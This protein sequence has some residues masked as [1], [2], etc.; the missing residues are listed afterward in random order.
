MTNFQIKYTSCVS[1]KIVRETDLEI[2][3]AKK[4][5]TQAQGDAIEVRAIKSKACF[6]FIKSLFN[7][8]NNE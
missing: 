7:L 3:F 4:K 5:K 1:A 2:K 8:C 6:V